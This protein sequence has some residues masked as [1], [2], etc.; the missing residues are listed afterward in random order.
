MQCSFFPS[1]LG[2]CGHGL[3]P[4]SSNTIRAETVVLDLANKGCDMART[5]PEQLAR[6]LQ[7]L[8][9]DA[10]DLVKAAA[11]LEDRQVAKLG[12]ELGRTL[13]SARGRLRDFRRQS[14]KQVAAMAKDSRHYAHDHPLTTVGVAACV[15]LVLGLLL[16]SRRD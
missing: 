2:A 5:Y 11:K 9:E 12:S 6:H 16:G 8:V 4:V 13:D 15:A 14:G 3:S 1:R 10:E 7:S